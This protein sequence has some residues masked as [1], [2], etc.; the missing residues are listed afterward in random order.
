MHMSSNHFAV[1]ALECR[2]D[3]PSFL[4]DL[5]M[6]LNP[7]K[8]NIYMLTQ[9]DFNWTV[10]QWHS[11]NMQLLICHLV[12]VSEIQRTLS[13][14]FACLALCFFV[15]L[16]IFWC[17]LR[18]VF[19]FYICNWFLVPKPSSSPVLSLSGLLPA[20]QSSMVSSTAR[21]LLKPSLSS[22]STAA[23]FILYDNL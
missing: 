1:L 11:L 2:I 6:R 21:L 9:Q 23:A 17:D 4:R 16:L 14:V 3:L 18:L 10:F 12:G 8:N 20:T 19:H 7:K 5:I 13:K 15:F 22:V